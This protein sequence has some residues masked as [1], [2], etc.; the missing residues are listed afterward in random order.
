MENLLLSSFSVLQRVSG[1][2]RADFQRNRRCIFYRR[3]HCRERRIHHRRENLRY[4]HSS[5]HIVD[6]QPKDVLSR[7]NQLQK[8]RQRKKYSDDFVESQLEKYQKRVEELKNWIKD[9]QL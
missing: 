8:N 3:S 5:Q 4:L 2:F 7:P 1:I 9:E 6:F